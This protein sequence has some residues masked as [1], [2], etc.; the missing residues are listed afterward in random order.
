MV[1]ALDP[2]VVQ[3]R[4]GGYLEAVHHGCLA[5]TRPDGTAA[6]ALG[7]VGTPFLPRSAIKPLLYSAALEQR[8][9]PG[10]LVDDTPFTAANGWSPSN[11]YGP[12]E[13]AISV[14]QA[15]AVVLHIEQLLHWVRSSR[16]EYL[17]D[18]C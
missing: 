18:E 13:G 11:S 4:R 1:D 9:M 17:G 3:V 16:V 15:C 2:A 6:L 5:V 7:D 8:I 14:R 12:G 10:T